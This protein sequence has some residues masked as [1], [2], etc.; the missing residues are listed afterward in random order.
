MP[1]IYYGEEVARGGS[2]WPTNRNDMPWGKRDIRPGKGVK[3]D[4]GLREYYQKIIAARRE[5][6]ALTHGEYVELSTDGDLLVF[7]KRDEE[8]S[9]AV[10]VAVNRGDAPAAFEAASPTEWGGVGMC[11]I[12]SGSTLPAGATLEVTIPGA[13]AQYWVADKHKAGE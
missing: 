7:A 9:D 2:V 1:V 5:H 4:D 11:E 13:T 10:I 12:I 8:T 3:R 6:P